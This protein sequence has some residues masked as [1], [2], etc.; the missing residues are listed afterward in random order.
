MRYSTDFINSTQVLERPR[1][2]GPTVSIGVIGAG[3][4][5][6]KVIREIQTLSRRQGNVRLH[7][8][9]DVSSA[10]LDRCRQE[11]GP[12]DCGTDYASLLADPNL[13]AVHIC[14]PDPTHFEI[15]EAFI[16]A[17]KNV[18]V[19]KPIT[20]QSREAYQLVE[21]A[22]AQKIVLSTGHVHRFSN[23]LKAL[24]SALEPMVLGEPY[25]LQL[26]WTGV[27]SPQ[28]NGDVI[29][30]LA[31]H[32]FDIANSITGQW[33]TRISCAARGYKDR[34]TIEVAFIT[35]EYENGLCASIEVSLLDLRQRRS[36]RIVAEGG[37]ANLD[38]LEQTVSLR[39]EGR[40]VKMPVIPSNILGEEIE[41][42]ANC[43][44]RNRLSQT[45][46][47][48]NDGLLGAHVVACLEAARESLS[49]ECTVNVKPPSSYG[50]SVVMN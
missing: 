12:L 8:V 34:Q 31:P 7:S 14:T 19:E 26:E 30:D 33:P 41:H 10:A 36:L 28:D 11:F 39:Q 48:D 44:R 35:C 42:F 32:P 43:I 18:L 4:W 47:N 50:E 22:N 27:Q 5:G 9:V 25:Y 40:F 24:K 29:I 15:A 23:G 1:L 20:L 49:E 2:Q 17:G 46:T 21:L 45:F 37:T 38:F 3:Y 6:R 16:K 13:A